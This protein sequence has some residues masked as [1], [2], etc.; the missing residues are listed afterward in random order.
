[1]HAYRAGYA[2]RTIRQLTRISDERCG[3]I[4]RSVEEGV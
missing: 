2:S 1:M 3:G 4:R